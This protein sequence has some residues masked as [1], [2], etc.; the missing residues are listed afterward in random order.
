MSPGDVGKGWGSG[1]EQGRS[2]C[3][4]VTEQVTAMGGPVVLT[5]QD[6]NPGGRKRV[7]VDQFASAKVSCGGVNSP[8]PSSPAYSLAEQPSDASEKVFV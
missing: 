1:T 2:E 4:C 5:P 7:F 8:G 6:D 3:K